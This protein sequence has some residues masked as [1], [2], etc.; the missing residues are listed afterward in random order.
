MSPSS[1]ISSPQINL[2]RIYL[3]ESLYHNYVLH[4]SQTSDHDQPAWKFVSRLKHIETNLARE[5]QECSAW[6]LSLYSAQG[7]PVAATATRDPRRVSISGR[8]C[9]SE[10]RAVQVNAAFVNMLRQQK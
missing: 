8:S 3:I 5:M 10:N 1:M 7:T 9:Y 6:P 4:W 2:A